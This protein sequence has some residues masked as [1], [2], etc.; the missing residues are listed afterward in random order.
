[1]SNGT[2]ICPV[3]G[4]ENSTSVRLCVKCQS[5]LHIETHKIDQ[6][7]EYSRGNPKWGTRSI[8]KRLYLHIQGSVES[9]E[10]E[11]QDG[12]EM[13][14]G[15]FDVETNKAPEIDLTPFGADE[16]GLSRNHA[17]LTYQNGSLK[18]ADLNSANFTYLN[19]QKLLP[20]QP[21]LLRDGD[22]IRLGRMLLTIQ[23][24]E[25]VPD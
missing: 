7:D 21:R 19:G 8:G 11:L 25:K 22:E 20:R 5:V 10:Y 16:K 4:F 6:P 24:G 15:R 13:I 12:A 17:V 2:V 3:C 23:F 14:V 1:M 18:V 9:L